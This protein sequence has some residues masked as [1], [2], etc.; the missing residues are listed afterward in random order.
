MA[1]PGEGGVVATLCRALEG[2]GIESWVIGSHAAHIAAAPRG[3]PRR[4]AHVDPASPDFAADLA[5]LLDQGG[6]DAVHAHGPVAAVALARVHPHL[7]LLAS[8]ATLRGPLAGDWRR[9]WQVRRAL[10][11]MDEVI[12]TD[13]ALAARFARLAGRP[14]ETLADPIDARWFEMAARRPD[15]G[16]PFRF[17]MAA[18]SPDARRLPAGVAAADRL[19]AQGLQVELHV[20]AQGKPAQ[21]LRHH[22]AAR[23]WLVVDDAAGDGAPWLAGKHA[24]LLPAAVEAAPRLLGEALAAGLPVI[25]GS[26][27][28]RQAMVAGDA[29]MLADATDSQALGWQMTRI[30]L[31]ELLWHRMARAARAAAAERAPDRVAAGLRLRYMRLLALD[32]PAPGADKLRAR[33][34]GNPWRDIAPA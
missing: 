33:G 34:G 9:A 22:A 17:A 23:P 11:A 26:D 6:F 32:R 10:R 7:P 21:A 28:V 19:V 2:A 15:P 18:P 8:L 14:V 25:A 1:A 5:R 29:L 20:A 3:V 12:A 16:E 24:L 13:P 4:F 27:V 30:A 31:D